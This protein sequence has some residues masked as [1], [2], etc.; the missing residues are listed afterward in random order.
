MEC[1]I[2]YI[3]YIY[4]RIAPALPPGIPDVKRLLMK[5][6]LGFESIHD[7]DAFHSIDLSIVC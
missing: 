2:S 6:I 3:Y 1:F 5:S 4:L 7:K